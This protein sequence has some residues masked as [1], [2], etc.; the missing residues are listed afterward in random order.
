MA[1]SSETRRLRLISAIADRGEQPHH[2]RAQ[3]DAAA[4][5]DRDHDPGKDRM[6]ERVADE[7]QAAQHH[8]AAEHPGGDAGQH[9]RHQRPAHELELQRVGQVVPSVVVALGGEDAHAADLDRGGRRRR[10]PGARR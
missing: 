2:H 6:R 8:V 9:D 7:G 10:R 4:D 5:R 3:Q 1:V